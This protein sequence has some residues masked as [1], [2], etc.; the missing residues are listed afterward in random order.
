[1]QVL[2]LIKELEKY[3]KDALIEIAVCGNIYPASTLAHW[4]KDRNELETV[5]I[6][7]P[8][9]DKQCLEIYEKHNARPHGGREKG[10][11]E[12]ETR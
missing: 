10:L 12:T 5:M 3:P 9:L 1:M 7:H 2:E 6:T 8:P 4:T 11:H